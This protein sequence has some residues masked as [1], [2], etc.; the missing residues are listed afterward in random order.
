MY[1]QVVFLMFSYIKRNIV[2]LKFFVNNCKVFLKK[3]KGKT[4][5]KPKIKYFV[6]T[7]N[8]PKIIW[9]NSYF[10]VMGQNTKMANQIVGYFKL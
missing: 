9:R 1:D 3:S 7:R 8:G 10:Q 6:L 4:A 2:F 5:I